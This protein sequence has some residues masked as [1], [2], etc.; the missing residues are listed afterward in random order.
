LDRIR[1]FYPANLGC[2]SEDTGG[3]E[4]K[5]DSTEG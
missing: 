2:I 4:V 3:G 1:V 5:L